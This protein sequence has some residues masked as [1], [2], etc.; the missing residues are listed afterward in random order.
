[1]TYVILGVVMVGIL[2]AI[3][4]TRM[5]DLKEDNKQIDFRGSVRRL[6]HNPNYVWGVVAQ[7]F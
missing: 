1:M 3:Y 2:A 5:P 4:W 7:F 6:L